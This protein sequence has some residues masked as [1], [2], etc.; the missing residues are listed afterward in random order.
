MK[1]KKYFKKPMFFYTLTVISLLGFT[2]II[3]RYST[4]FDLKPMAETLM[5]ILIG[6]GLIIQSRIRSVIQNGIQRD[7][8]LNVVALAVGVAIFITGL[9][10]YP[11]FN[12]DNPIFNAYKILASSIAILIIV[13]NTFIPK[14]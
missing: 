11:L 4:G 10:G 12:I 5:F 6:M 14:D 3:L 1:L 13:I 9:L 7:E 8:I 2:S